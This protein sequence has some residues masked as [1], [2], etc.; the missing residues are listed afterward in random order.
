MLKKQ[1]RLPKIKKVG[2]ESYASPAFNIR[3][4]ENKEGITRFGFVVSK[5][6]DKRAVARNKTKRVLSFAAER[7]LKK[8]VNK[9]IVIFAKNKLD[10]KQQEGI[11]TEL[12]SILEKA[13]ILK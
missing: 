2:G 7:L 1:N 6:I 5:K 3:I 11:V 4:F 12:K 9:D 13:K 8:I 10:S